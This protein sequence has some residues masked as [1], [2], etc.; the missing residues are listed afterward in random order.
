M[1]SKQQCGG[2]FANSLPTVAPCEEREK[3]ENAQMWFLFF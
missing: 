3:K 1:K 2:R